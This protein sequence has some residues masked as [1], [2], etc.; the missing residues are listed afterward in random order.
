MATKK[1][2]KKFKGHARRP[3]A[4]KQAKVSATVQIGRKR[5]TDVIVPIKVSKK[6]EQGLLRMADGNG[7]IHISEADL[8]TAVGNYLRPKAEPID[9]VHIDNEQPV[10]IDV[11]SMQMST[12]QAEEP[13]NILME[14]NKIIYG[15]REKAYG[16]P[17]FNLDSI[18]RFWSVYLQRK[19]PG[20]TDGADF[21][22]EDVAQMMILLKTARLIH[23]PTHKD[24]LVDQA[25]Y[26]ALQG[27]INGL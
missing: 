25:G 5:P 27:R 16:N 11:I 8:M 17:R 7:V 24:S 10:E 26:A 6:T 9:A 19:F 12:I 14:A 18:A 2:A 21:T 23:N 3:E 1:P 15:D 4:P 22:A 13:I 20:T